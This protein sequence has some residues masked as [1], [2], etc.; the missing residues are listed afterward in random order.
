MLWFW[1]WSFKSTTLL[2]IEWIYVQS[3]QMKQKHDIFANS[4]WIV[5]SPQITFCPMKNVL[6]HSLF[7][8]HTNTGPHSREKNGLLQRQ[9]LENWASVCPLRSFQAGMLSNLTTGLP[10]GVWLLKVYFVNGLPLFHL[11]GMCSLLIITRRLQTRC[12]ITKIFT[13]CYL[14]LSWLTVSA[15]SFSL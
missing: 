10:P 12:K 6:E 13:T 14:S 8:F 5:G 15:F 3:W 11:Q 1:P 4:V 2:V 9:V 7:N